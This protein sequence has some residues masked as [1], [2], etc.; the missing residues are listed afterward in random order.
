MA[1]RTIAPLG[2]V[3][4]LAATLLANA[5]SGGL[6]LQS[7]GT[8]YDAN[9]R[10]A[11][12][13]DANFANTP[14]GRSIVASQG[15]VG[16]GPTG[17]MDYPTAIE[18]VRALNSYRQQ[19]CAG[20]GYLCHDDWQLPVTPSQD[21]SCVVHRGFDGNSFGPRCQ[22]S[23]F[24]SLFYVGLGLAYPSTVAPAFT[25]RLGALRNVQPGLYWTRSP[26][27]ETGFQTFSFLSGLSG[28]NT[29][30]YNHLHVMAVHEGRIPGSSPGDLS[31][32]HKGV[33]PYVSGPAAGKAVFDVGSDLSWL[34]DANLAA[35]ESFGIEAQ[36]FLPATPNS[37]AITVPVL[38]PGGGVLFKAA[39]RWVQALSATR[40]AGTA[41]WLLPEI[42]DLQAL[43]MGLGLEPGNPALVAEGHNGPFSG[44][45]PFSYWACPQSPSTPNR[46]DYGKVLNVRDGVAMRWSFNF[47]TGFQGTSQESKKYYVWVYHPGR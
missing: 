9:L 27:G 43:Y 7:N 35:T 26:A 34:V 29:I 11:W 23:A 40:F 17:L 38:A 47:D 16:V 39:Q 5:A 13:A 3:S 8:V 10:V 21:P 25:N 15:I 46:C 22:S 45:Q 37:S 6:E 30:K 19:G 4:C 32:V 1:N 18:Y 41:Q 42:T 24:G 44:V 33:I 12:L 28:S 2:F 14:A 36:E 20:P 31:Q